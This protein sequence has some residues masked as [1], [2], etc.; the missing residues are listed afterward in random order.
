MSTLTETTPYHAKSYTDGFFDVSGLHGFLP[1]R[2][3]LTKLPERYADLQ[4]LMVDLPTHKVYADNISGV[5]AHSG[6]IVDRIA[7][8]P[9]YT[10]IVKQETDVFVWQALYRALTFLCSA[11]TL[12]A[13]HHTTVDGNY[14]RGRSLLPGH[15]ARPLVW[16]AEKLDVYP[17]LDYH[18]SYSLGNY[19]KKDPAG[20]L[21]WKNL[22]MACKFSGTPVSCCY[23]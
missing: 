17:F 20:T 3:P 9:D 6:E 23:C 1:I 16:V 14:G 15:V 22:D 21:N 8:L 18:Y 13:S 11:Y 19:V 7:A 5:L 12:E 10:E 2:D 4:Q